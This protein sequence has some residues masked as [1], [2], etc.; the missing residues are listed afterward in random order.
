MLRRIEKGVGRR[1]ERDREKER[2]RGREKESEDGGQVERD[3]EDNLPDI[4]SSGTV[5]SCVMSHTISR[6]NLIPIHWRQQQR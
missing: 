2:G 4:M 6:G 1:G 5:R 3:I